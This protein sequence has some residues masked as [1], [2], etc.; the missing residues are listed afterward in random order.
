[1]YYSTKS[2]SQA[3]PESSQTTPL[4]EVIAQADQ[5]I[6]L[7][8]PARILE[9]LHLRLTQDIRQIEDP[10]EIDPLSQP[11][12]SVVYMV[13]ADVMD[14]DACDRLTRVRNAII[15]TGR[16]FV[17]AITSFIPGAYRDFTRS[18]G[19]DDCITE[20]NLLL[21]LDEI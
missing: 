15:P 16:A 7:A 20:A 1:M 8:V 18:Q 13:G 4:R 21:E 19:A 12:A 3:D 5:I 11:D 17:C 2:N 10:S 9:A 6:A 14:A